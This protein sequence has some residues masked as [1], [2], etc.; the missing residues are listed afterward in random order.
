MKINT[1]EIELHDGLTIVVHFGRFLPNRVTCNEQEITMEEALQL[2]KQ[3]KE[4]ITKAT[5]TRRKKLDEFMKQLSLF[6][7]RVELMPRFKGQTQ[8][9]R[10]LKRIKGLAVF[11]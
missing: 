3:S 7:A 6:I 5:T 2:I 8:A 4:E 10:A 9:V 1:S 11:K